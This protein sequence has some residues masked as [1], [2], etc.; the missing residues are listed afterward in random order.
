MVEVSQKKVYIVHRVLCK[1]KKRKTLKVTRLKRCR[2]L[3]VLVCMLFFVIEVVRCLV[4]RLLLST[5]FDS[6][7]FYC[8]YYWGL[9]FFFFLLLCYM[10]E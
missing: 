6:Y 7:V 5:E 2:R 9:F 4:A 10:T 3:R 1:Q 8:A